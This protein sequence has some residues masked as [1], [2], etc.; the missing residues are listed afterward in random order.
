[1][2]DDFDTRKSSG[3][4]FTRSVMARRQAL[5]EA[6]ETKGQ[7]RSCVVSAVRDTTAF[8]NWE[9]PEREIFRMG[10]NSLRKF[11]DKVLIDSLASSELSGWKYLDALRRRV[12]TELSAATPS[13]RRV[14][15][16]H[17]EQRH[18]IAQIAKQL[19]IMEAT[20][21]IQTKAYLFLFQQLQGL[22]KNDGIEASVRARIF[23]MLNEHDELY[24]A[25]FGPGI[26]DFIRPN[27]VEVIQR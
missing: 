24:G 27:N 16:K 26:S 17:D 14:A 10:R 8:A 3:N 5:L 22:A 4:S 21:S 25:I 19:K 9:W 18:H 6:L 15:A 20:M 12:K 7:A 23:N 1:M 11:S 2:D 13:R